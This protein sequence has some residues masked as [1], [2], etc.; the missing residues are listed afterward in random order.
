MLTVLGIDP[1]SVSTGFGL[2][3]TDG[4]RDFHVAHGH[5]PLTTPGDSG[6]FNSRMGRLYTLI[7]ELVA[8]YVP[9]EAAIEQVFVSHNAQSALKLGQARGAALAALVNRRLPVH[10]YTPRLVKQ[11]VTGSG[12]ADKQQ[13][14][15][16]VVRLLNLEKPPQSDAADA[17]AIALCHAHA[18]SRARRTRS[19][20]N[21]L[22]GRKR[23]ARRWRSA[24]VR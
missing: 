18:G 5:W 19:D 2:I 9:D 14:N 13:V 22:P 24:P 1:G 15:G 10:E 8:Q 6:D 12:S 20:T 4:I 16:M 23:R 7:D 21:S 11:A 17:L 3:K